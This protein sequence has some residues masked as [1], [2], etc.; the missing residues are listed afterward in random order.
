M[1]IKAAFLVKVLYRGWPVTVCLC[2]GPVPIPAGR[3]ASQESRATEAR[4]S[5]PTISASTQGHLTVSHSQTCLPA[6]L[7]HSFTHSHIQSI[8]HSLTQLINCS[9]THTINE[10]LT[11]SF[12][13][14]LVHSC[15]HPCTHSCTHLLTSLMCQEMVLASACDFWMRVLFQQS[16]THWPTK[17]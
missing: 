17:Q 1:V 2:S 12:A 16:Y 11:H 4:S 13:H 5:T 7:G 15:T 9:L 6:L 10:L 14:L 8:S 3:G